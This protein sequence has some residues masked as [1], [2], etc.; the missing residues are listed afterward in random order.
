[1]IQVSKHKQK[2]F[3]LAII[4]ILAFVIWPFI[5]HSSEIYHGP[6]PRRN[7]AVD[8]AGSI[9]AVVNK[10]RQL[11]ASYGPKLVVAPVELRL[12]N[13]DPEMSVRTEISQPLEK[14]F[15][16]AKNN[17]L[18]LLLVS[19]YRSYS[20]QAQVY[21]HNISQLGQQT[22]DSQSARAGH[23]EH[24][25]GLAVDLGVISRQCELQV[26]FASTAE[27]KWLS[28]NSYKYGFILRYPADKTNI[29][30]FSYEPW[31]FRYIGTDLSYKLHSNG[32]TLEQY[33]NLP[34]FTDYPAKTFLLK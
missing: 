33:F 14:L 5:H 25:T 31:H 32:Q 20:E 23:S 10:G 1:M 28:Q 16:A 17:N 26:C 19:G 27:G 15:T 6:A 2:L 18:Q 21:S 9:W 24:Q 34:I 30:G 11:P 8:Q 12:P 7:N 29:T 3:G 4:V 22:A 13:S